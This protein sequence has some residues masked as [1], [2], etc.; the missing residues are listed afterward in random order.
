[1]P[2]EP[3]KNEKTQFSSLIFNTLCKIFKT[4]FQKNSD[5]NSVSN[6]FGIRIFRTFDI[7]KNS[8]TE[9]FEYQNTRSFKNI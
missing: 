5:K 1:M 3:N 7:R 8:N 4:S 9:Y 2:I 6:I